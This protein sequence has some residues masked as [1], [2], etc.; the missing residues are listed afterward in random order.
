MNDLRFALR[1]LAKSPGFTAATVLT[2]A[3]G[4]GSSTAIFSVAD[5]VLFRAPPYPAPEQLV[6]LGYKTAR[7]GFLPSVLPI[8]LAT[9]RE[10]VK[11]FSAI[12]AIESSQ[13]NVVVDGA[14][15]GASLGR[16]SIEHFATFGAA[17]MLGRGFAPG[18]DQAGADQVVVLSHRLWRSRFGSDP[19]VLGRQVTVGAQSCRVVGVLPND[20]APPWP[21][22]ADLF[23]PLVLKVDPARP[24]GS[25]LMDAI[26]RLQPGHAA[27]QALAEMTSLKLPVDAATARRLADRERRVMS[28][29]EQMRPASIT[30]A[31]W[32]LLAAVG[33]LYAIACANAGNLM[34]SRLHGRRRELSVRLALGCGRSELVRLLLLENFALT[35][36]AGAAGLLVAQWAFPALLRLAPGGSPS[37][38]AA[39]VDWRA[40]VFTGGLVA[41]TALLVSVVPA[42]R[43]AQAD[44][45]EG[46]KEGGQAQGDSRRLRQVRSGLVVLESALAVALLVGAG[47]MVRSVQKLQQIDRG[48][49]PT[50]KV[51]VWLQIPGGYTS[52][53]YRAP[54]ARREFYQKL[55]ERLLAVPGVQGVA[56]TAVVPMAGTST[57][58]LKKTDGME[59]DAA[60]NP[61]TPGYRKML[62]LPLLR[63]RWFDDAAPGSEPVIVINETMAR[64]YFGEADPIG[65]AFASPWGPKPTPWQ[66]IGV[67]RD[68]RERTREAPRPQLYYPYWQ[69]TSQSVASLLLRLVHAPDDA[70]ADGVRRAVF[71]VD[72]QVATMRLQ[73]LSDAATA[74]FS[75]ERYTLAV[76]Q[77]LSA[78]ALGL[79]VLGLFAVM[80]Y[81]VAQ[82]MGEFG[83][84]LAFGA[85]PEDLFRLV[86]RRGI[87]LTAFGVTVGF[88]A[89]WALTRFLQSLL[90]ETSAV[91]PVVYVVVA[92]LLLAAAA[93][94]CWLPARRATRVDITKLLRTE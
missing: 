21:H 24:F 51:A 42:W 35:T 67:V 16:V 3:L 80:A 41:L 52:D 68:V 48:F 84:R 23:Q 26:G 73:P 82:R 90:F 75:Q 27:Q 43:L 31:Y 58:N 19:N 10:H 44:V 85:M 34:L 2:L 37:W 77:V 17:P 76:L 20:F 62:G 65:R 28:L 94:G 32:A 92:L 78:L 8:E 4:I 50:N 71:A 93:L 18:E 74:Q 39:S 29:A 56:I 11:S 36:L 57:A 33:F 60:V 38:G 83:V 89:A 22:N 49:D 81:N 47:L 45:T 40:L 9:Y 1:S 70:L 66:V 87:A 6:V 46:L 25:F 69:L 61:V 12:A 55:E 86:L 63:G 54:E 79:A 72:P 59:F 5:R 53:R 64:V 13:V 88:G 15:A 30:P 91:D 14:P 7:F